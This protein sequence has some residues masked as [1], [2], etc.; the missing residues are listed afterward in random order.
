MVGLTEVTMCYS[1]IALELSLQYV[2][3]IGGPDITATFTLKRIHFLYLIY[4]LTFSKKKKSVLLLE[5]KFLK[6]I[7]FYILGWYYYMKYIV[8]FPVNGCRH[9]FYEFGLQF[10]FISY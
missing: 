6:E 3:H 10:S 2:F 5:A 8:F 1:I 7:I 9:T 4:L